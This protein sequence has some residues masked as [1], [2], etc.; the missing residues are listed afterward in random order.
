MDVTSS[1]SRGI[2]VPSQNHSCSRRVPTL[3]S[4]PITVTFRAHRRNHTVSTPAK[5]KTMHRTR[6]VMNK[7]RQDLRNEGHEDLQTHTVNRTSTFPCYTLTLVAAYAS[8]H[9]VYTVVWTCPHASF[10]FDSEVYPAQKP[11]SAILKQI[12]PQTKSLQTKLPDINLLPLKTSNCNNFGSNG[13]PAK[14]FLLA[15]IPRPASG[16]DRRCAACASPFFSASLSGF[17][18]IRIL[19]FPCLFLCQF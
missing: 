15:P 6:E 2:W 13:T 18:R 1:R 11:I 10:H 7:N 12:N 16:L 4:D 14:L 3:V 17:P 19:S 8:E 5:A 9:K